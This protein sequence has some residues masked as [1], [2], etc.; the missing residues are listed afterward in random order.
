[1]RVPSGR[2]S[3]SLERRPVDNSFGWL[4]TFAPLLI[5]LVDAAL[6]LSGAVEVYGYGFWIAVAVNIVLAVLDSRLLNSRG[7]DVSTGLAVFL[8]PVYLVQRARATE[9]T[10]AMPAVWA[11]VFVASVAGSFALERTLG[12]VQ[13]DMPTVE[14]AVE[15][16]LD[17]ALGTAT[18]AVTCPDED[19]Y[20]VGEAF[21]CSVSGASAVTSMQVTVESADGSITWQPAG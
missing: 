20:Q 8:V 18:A 17:D 11:A 7:Y 5:L 6:L 21:Y 9:Q 15:D 10:Y 16:W 2:M 14:V 13:L 3:E 19:A 1:M 4:L 12:V